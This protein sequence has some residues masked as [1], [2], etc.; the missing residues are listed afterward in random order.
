MP[1]HKTFLR[2]A[3][4]AALLTCLFCPPAFAISEGDLQ[5][6]IEAAGKEAVS[7]SVL[8]W[9]L[10]A[11]AFLK[12]SQKIDSFLASLGIHVGHTGGS[13]MAEAMIAARGLGSVHS[14]SQPH[15]SGGHQKGASSPAAGTGQ[16]GTFLAGGLVGGL[17]GVVSRQVTNSA[18]R[19]ATAPPGNQTAGRTPSG[20]SSG[21]MASGLSAGIGGHLYTSSVTKG[22]DFANNI[23][24]TV[25]AGSPSSTG[26]ITG[27]RAAEALHS[28]MGY[29]ALEPG[30]QH[31]PSFKNVEIGGGRITGTEIS[32]EHPE[33]IA[34]GMYHTSQYSAPDGDY[35]TIQAA[36]GSSW[37]KQYAA[38]TVNRSPHMAPDGSVAYEES[39]VKKLPPAPKRKE[40]G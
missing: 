35:T 5:A 31:I 15:A 37:Y 39:I 11:V 40:K 7:G 26:F 6:Q 30:A 22:G 10:C 34:F 16:A 21:S 3:F 8:V 19:T 9:F 18:L 36:D 25:A 24:G 2:A 38:D 14:F 12:V 29:A 23:I 32:E 28:Y 20:T 13:L 33:G 27:Q 4:L 1:Y 17:A